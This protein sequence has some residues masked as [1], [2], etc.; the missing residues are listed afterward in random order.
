MVNILGKNKMFNINITDF[1]KLA[2]E[3][4]QDVHESIH[5]G[6][7]NKQYLGEIIILDINKHPWEIKLRYTKKRGRYLK[8]AS[9]IDESQKIRV[10]ADGYKHYIQIT[11]EEW[12]IFHTICGLQNQ[13][14]LYNRAQKI[15][16]KLLGY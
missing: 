9:Q 6:H 12:D 10:S 15:L 4:S 1:Y 14:Q 8:I 13:E 11:P 3:V 2:K 16:N 7:K 5:N